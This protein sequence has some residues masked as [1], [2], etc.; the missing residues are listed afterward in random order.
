MAKN[1]PKSPQ[2]KEQAEAR[3]AYLKEK[4]AVIAGKL[5]LAEETLAKLS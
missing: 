4:A 2:T 5:K 3:I 1:P